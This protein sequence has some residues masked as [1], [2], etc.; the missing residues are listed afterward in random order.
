ML[1]IT[2]TAIQSCGT[3]CSFACAVVGGTEQCFCPPGF[4][5]SSTDSTQCVGEYRVHTQLL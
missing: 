3:E 2:L 4:W 1:H 5:L